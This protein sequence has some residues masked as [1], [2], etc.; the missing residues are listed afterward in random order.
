MISLYLILLTNRKSW[1]KPGKTACWCFLACVIK[2]IFSWKRFMDSWSMFWLHVW[3]PM[4]HSANMVK[5]SVLNTDCTARS[6]PGDKVNIQNTV[7]EKEFHVD[8]LKLQVFCNGIIR[9]EIALQL[10]LKRWAHWGQM[11]TEV[12]LKQTRTQPSLAFQPEPDYSLTFFLTS[13]PP[14]WIR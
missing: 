8:I 1:D 10:C 13:L 9:W 4:K 12:C 5:N 11:L 14:C 2:D 7:A 6:W 3:T